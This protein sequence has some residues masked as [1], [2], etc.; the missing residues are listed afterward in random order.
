[1]IKSDGT[2]RYNVKKIFLF[3]FKR[4]LFFW[5]FIKQRI[6]KKFITIQNFSTTVL[7]N[8]NKKCYLSNKSAIY[9]D[10]CRVMWSWTA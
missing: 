1:L 5:I 10:F 2:E 4:T 9:N 8:D 3:P 7:N 6:L